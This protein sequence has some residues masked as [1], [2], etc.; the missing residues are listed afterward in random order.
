MAISMLAIFYESTTTDFNL[1]R[2]LNRA[3]KPCR[4]DNINTSANIIPAT[5]IIAPAMEASIHFA[6]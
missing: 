2:L 6:L 1:R 3:S 5:L 4:G